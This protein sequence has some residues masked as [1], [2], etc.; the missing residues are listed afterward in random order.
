MLING[1]TCEFDLVFY[2]KNT[3]VDLRSLRSHATQYLNSAFDKLIVDGSFDTI[4]F[5]TDMDV[6]TQFGSMMFDADNDSD[7]LER[8]MKFW[9]F[10]VCHRLVDDWTVIIKMTSKKV[11]DNN[12]KLINE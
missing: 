1:T 6:T 7:D 12:G 3:F 10:P 9:V 2:K 4:T 5:N 8:F 11:Y